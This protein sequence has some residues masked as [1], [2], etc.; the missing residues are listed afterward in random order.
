METIREATDNVV[1]AVE[2]Q[3]Q[4]TVSAVVAHA[5]K[6]VEEAQ[7]TAQAI[8]DA[9]LQSEIGRQ[10][11]DLR[12]DL[13]KCQTDLQS[14]QPELA[15]MKSQL[16]EIQ[17]TMAASLTLQAA[18]LQPQNA[19]VSVSLTPEQSPVREAVET[20]TAALPGNLSENAV[21][22]SPAPQIQKPRKRFL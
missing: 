11:N 5:E 12:G 17:A 9:A 4:E 21:A 10:V 8:A 20:V 3:A 13:I 2:T 19:P 18:T 7:E 22:E 14:L 16:T 15:T 6:R 1:A